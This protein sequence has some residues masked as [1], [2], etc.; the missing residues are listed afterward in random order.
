M[1]KKFTTHIDPSL[2]ESSSITDIGAM[3]TTVKIGDTV[4]QE[5]DL[6]DMLLLV[7]VIRGIPDNHPLAELKRDLQTRK[8]FAALGDTL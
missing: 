7:Q 6:Q 4:V 2:F 3:K 5:E 8:A 1:T